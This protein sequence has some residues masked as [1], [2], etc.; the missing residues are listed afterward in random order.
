MPEHI[1]V[2][3]TVSSSGAGGVLRQ[4]RYKHTVPRKLAVSQRLSNGRRQGRWLRFC[5]RAAAAGEVIG[6]SCCRSSVKS[7]GPKKN[8]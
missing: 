5:S 2:L 4:P 1:G 8:R 7:G 6:G 3:R